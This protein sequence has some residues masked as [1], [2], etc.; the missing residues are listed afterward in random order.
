MRAEATLEWG[1]AILTLLPERAVWW[2]A[3]RTVFIADPHFGKAAAFRF[4]GIPVP[5]TSHDDDLERLSQILTMTG[6]QRLVILGDFLHAKTGRSE[7]MFAALRAWREKHAAVEMVL[8]EGNHD[9]H[10]GGLPEE[11]RIACV[12]GPWALGAFRCRHE[13]EEDA[14]A[15][16]LAGHIHPAFRLSDRMGLSVRAPCFYFSARVGILPAFGSFTGMHGVRPVAGERV[17]L[18]G[19]ESVIEIRGA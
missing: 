4:A 8:V 7:G 15:Y 10:A 1:G 17:F 9:R 11:L 6:A 18:V 13:P 16:V 12:K 3:E 5:E 19:G 2:A 14:G